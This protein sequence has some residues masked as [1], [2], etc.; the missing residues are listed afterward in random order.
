[1]NINGTPYRTIWLGNNGWSVG[2][3]DQT[4]LPHGCVAALTARWRRRRTPSAPCRCGA[5]RSSAPR[6]PMACVWRCA[7]TPRTGRWSG[8]SR[9]SASAAHRGQPALGAGGDAPRRAQPAAPAAGGR[10]LQA[11]GGDL[12]RGRGHQ[13]AHR[14]AGAAADRGGGRAR[15]RASVNVLTHCNAGW[16]ASVD[17]GTALAP[18]YQAH[19]AACRACVGGRDAAAQPGRGLTA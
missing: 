12:R 1:M 14:R 6:R 15:S 18:I 3:I 4:R 5:R 9:C 19:D 11:R 2:I 17:W 16:L 10:R 8:P 13:P 7:W